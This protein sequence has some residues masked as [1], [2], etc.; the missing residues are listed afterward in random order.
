MARVGAQRGFPAAQLLSALTLVMAGRHQGRL[1]RAREHRRAVR[2][3]GALAEPGDEAAER[4]VA[5]DLREAFDPSGVHALQRVSARQVLLPVLRHARRAHLRPPAAALARWADNV[6]QRGRGL[7][8]L[9]SEEGQH[10]AA[11]SGHASLA[12]AVPAERAAPAPQ[13]P[14]VPAQLSARYLARLSLLGYR[15]GAVILRGWPRA[16]GR[17]GG[18]G[19]RDSR[20]LA[21]EPKSEEAPRGFVPSPEGNVLQPVQ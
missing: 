21:G 20:V 3:A 14:A 2:Q 12:D 6:G 5:Q 1:P 19:W 7:L 13:W 15:A 9:Q 8:A 17:G 10:D 4:G 18:E 11:R 16:N